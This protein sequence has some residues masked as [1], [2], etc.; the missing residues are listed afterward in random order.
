MNVSEAFKLSG[1]ISFYYNRK[2]NHSWA[3]NEE[4]ARTLG[5]TLY[6]KFCE[7]IKNAESRV[8]NLA[9][10]KHFSKEFLENPVAEKDGM[11]DME[12]YENYSFDSLMG[13]LAKIA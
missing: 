1:K 8:K 11:T 9:V 2:S 12:V 4:I 7:E 10:R 5:P 13:T 3:I 6:G